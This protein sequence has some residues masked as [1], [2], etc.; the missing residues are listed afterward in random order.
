ME[1]IY[2]F[3]ETELQRRQNYQL[4]NEA[5]GE[6]YSRYRSAPDFPAATGIGV[7]HHGVTIDCMAV[8]GDENLKINGQV[9]LNSKAS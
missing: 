8:T 5:R 4:F 7:C 9:H 6:Y 3:E 2:G 1:Q